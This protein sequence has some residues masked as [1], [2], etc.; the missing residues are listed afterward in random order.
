MNFQEIEKL[1]NKYFEGETSINEENQLKEY[2]NK[3]FL[4]P[5]LKPFKEQFQYFSNARNEEITDP[6]F[7]QMILNEIGERKLFSVDGKRKYLTYSLIG[8]A[9]SIIIIFGFFFKSP[10]DNLDDKNFAFANTFTD[11]EKAF[12]ETQRILK[13]ISNKFNS[14]VEPLNNISKF[15]EGVQNLNKMASFNEGMD[16]MIKISKFYEYKQLIS[17]QSVDTIQNIKN[18]K[19]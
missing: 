11:P 7:D 5:N 2:F 16:E 13:Y 1:L 10:L 4:P 3:D 18:N 8:I 9:A 19:L 6:D 17:N 14:G 15:D 12:T